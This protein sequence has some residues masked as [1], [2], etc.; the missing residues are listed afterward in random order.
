MKHRYYDSNDNEVFD[1]AIQVENYQK[2]WECPDNKIH[3][4]FEFTA[5][6]LLVIKAGLFEVTQSGRI[7]IMQ[8]ER[9]LAGAL[10]EKLRGHHL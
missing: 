1:N 2:T 10:L 9:M 5:K 4:I 8:T 3:S 7:S 6:E